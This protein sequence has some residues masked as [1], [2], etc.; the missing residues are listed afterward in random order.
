ME[1]SLRYEHKVLTLQHRHLGKVALEPFTTRLITLTGRDNSWP[2]TGIGCQGSTNLFD[3]V[4]LPKKS[5][6]PS[7][8]SHLI[9][10]YV[11]NRNPKYLLFLLN[12][13]KSPDVMLRLTDC[14]HTLSR[15]LQW[16]K[17]LFTCIFEGIGESGLQNRGVTH[18]CRVYAWLKC[19]IRLG[20]NESVTSL[21]EITLSQQREH[22]LKTD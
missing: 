11:L 13:T 22:F 10:F 15:A 14:V 7:P 16:V 18:Q 5:S 6:R 21:L 17:R 19:S 3:E 9:I 1:V 2:D 4:S 20:L 12:S 8:F